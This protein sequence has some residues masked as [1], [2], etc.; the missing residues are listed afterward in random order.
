MQHIWS[1]ASTQ[2]NASNDI[3]QKTNFDLLAVLAVPAG[4]AHAVCAALSKCD[5]HVNVE[6]CRQ[7]SRCLRSKQ[8]KKSSSGIKTRPCVKDAVGRMGLRWQGVH[9]G[10]QTLL[11]SLQLLRFCDGDCWLASLSNFRQKDTVCKGLGGKTNY[12]NVVCQNRDTISG[13]FMQSTDTHLFS[14]DLRVK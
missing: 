1:N 3:P 5:L 2:S 11:L 9:C 12:F 4:A 7:M 6:V 10:S 13:F 8:K 14:E